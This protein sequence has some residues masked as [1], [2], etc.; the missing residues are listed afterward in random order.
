M[1]HTFDRLYS[2]LSSNR[3]LE[4]QGLANEVPIFIQPYA[5]DREEEIAPMIKALGQRLKQAGVRIAEVDLFELLLEELKAEGLLKD[6]LQ[7]EPTYS[8]TELLATLKNYADCKSRIVPRLVQIMEQRGNQLTM[9]SGVGHVF[10]FLRAHT[11]LDSIQPAMMQH[12][13]VMFFPGD[14]IQTPGVGSQLRLFGS[15]PAKG[16][17]RAFN[18]DHYQLPSA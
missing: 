8:R 10:P 11:L 12:P 17:Y 5:V 4:M 18:L 14:Y 3:F 9:V 1:N 16:Y 6:L 13:L 7:D 15:L 2:I